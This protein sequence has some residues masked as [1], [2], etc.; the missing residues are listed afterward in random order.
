MSIKQI[1]QESVN[2]NPL[3]LKEALEAEMQARVRLALEAKMSEM[4]D[5]EDEDEDE[6]EDDEDMDESFD[7]S[8]YT[9]EEL[10]GFME[11]AEFDQLD[12]IS[13]K[14]LT[15]YVKKADKAADKS[16]SSAIKKQSLAMKGV[17]GA[18]EKKAKHSRDFD[19]RATGLDRANARLAK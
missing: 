19:K 1:I 7:L 12:E 5:D 16:F 6:D 2:R 10:E 14:T 11:S 15:S 13:K 8:D 18:A 4:H 3:G 9:I 17:P